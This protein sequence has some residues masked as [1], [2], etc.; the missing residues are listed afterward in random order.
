MAERVKICTGLRIRNVDEINQSD[1]INVAVIPDVIR[2]ENTS[3]STSDAILLGV[4]VKVEAETLGSD[5]AASNVAAEEP[6]VSNG[7]AEETPVTAAEAEAPQASSSPEV[8]VKAEVKE[9]SPID[10]SIE[11]PDSPV[12]RSC[13]KYGIKCY[14]NNA[15]HRSEE[16]HPGDDDYKMPD[17]PEP[18]PGT[19][20]CPYGTSCY[21]RNPAHF[22]GFSHSNVP[23]G[24]RFP[25]LFE[26][27]N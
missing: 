17:H 16:A 24:K 15:I 3:D 25:L 4:L 12:G 19:P 18:P 9:E 22:Q 13:C 5:P 27:L 26:I 11:I 10:E 14:R 6:P 21:R 7:E 23:L 20:K 8:K 1:V 2:E